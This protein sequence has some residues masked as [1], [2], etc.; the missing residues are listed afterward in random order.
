MTVAV[1][2]PFC[3]RQI[4]IKLPPLPPPVPVQSVVLQWSENVFT[5]D[6]PMIASVGEDGALVLG[7]TNQEA[8]RIFMNVP[9]GK[10]VPQQH[11]EPRAFALQ[12][13]HP[14]VLRLNMS[15]FDKVLHA[16]ITIVGAPAQ[17]E[18]AANKEHGEH[19]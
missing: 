5:D 10:V 9:L 19:S 15:V 13:I 11:G 12:E 2:C 4:Q 16:F 6:R 18:A 8:K 17:W 1:Q 3:T 14:G 7:L